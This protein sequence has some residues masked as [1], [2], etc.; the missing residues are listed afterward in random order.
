[1]KKHN[2][3]EAHKYV[4]MLL[5]INESN[6]DAIQLLITIINSKKSNDYTINYLETILEKQPLSFKLIE[7]YID[8]VRR[9]GK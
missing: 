3:N 2:F 9:V 7:L 5:R 8:V 1:V 4:D 6:E